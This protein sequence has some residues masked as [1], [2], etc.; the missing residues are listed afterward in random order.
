[1]NLT[2]NTCIYWELI[3][4]LWE[5]VQ[6]CQILV[7]NILC[8]V[9]VNLEAHLLVCF[10]NLDLSL[11][12]CMC[13]DCLHTV[14]N[15][16]TGVGVTLVL[17]WNFSGF[18]RVAPFNQEA[19]WRWGAAVHLA[20]LNKVLG[21]WSSLAW[22]QSVLRLYINV[23]STKSLLPIKASLFCITIDCDSVRKTENGWNIQRVRQ[24]QN[25]H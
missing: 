13:K 16:M 3:P 19:C 22:H 8:C 18:C 4:Q 23:F 11:Q 17:D 21:Q 10:D 14:S 1:M 6:I 20:R 12:I 24:H 7:M 2:I 9:D 15:L 25:E 5:M